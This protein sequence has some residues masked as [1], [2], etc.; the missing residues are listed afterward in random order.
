M[1]WS[2]AC[3]LLAVQVG[4]SLILVALS[5]VGLVTSVTALVSSLQLLVAISQLVLSIYLLRSSC[6]A[7]GFHDRP[8]SF[9]G[10]KN[11]TEPRSE[12]W[13]PGSDE[14]EPD[15]E[16]SARQSL[17]LQCQEL[18]ESL[19]R[20]RQEIADAGTREQRLKELL[21]CRSRSLVRLASQLTR[22]QDQR[23]PTDRGLFH[24]EVQTEVPTL[25][26]ID[27]EAALPT[28][29]SRPAQRVVELA[30]SSPAVRDMVLQRLKGEAREGQGAEPTE[31]KEAVEVTKT[32]PPLRPAEAVARKLAQQASDLERLAQEM[33]RLKEEL[34]QKDAELLRSREELEARKVINVASES[35]DV[36]LKWMED[37]GPLPGV[38]GSSKGMKQ[39]RQSFGSSGT[40]QLCVGPPPADWKV[41]L[42]L[43]LR[44]AERWEP[45][46]LQLTGTEE[47]NFLGL[48]WPTSEAD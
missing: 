38:M 16:A 19:T 4:Q 8:S 47:S 46:L 31:L 9:Q 12:A 27:P 18:S 1:P 5:L 7:H 29:T 33:Q 37:A 23:R 42:Q 11:A 6:G 14:E 20:L 30:A 39:L 17:Q 10:A 15:F 25:D 26:A 13:P 43:R 28:V 45:A 44:Q 41:F 48:L 34:K 3:P 21:R 32:S 40:V 36:K 22:A 24:V 35:P 2:L